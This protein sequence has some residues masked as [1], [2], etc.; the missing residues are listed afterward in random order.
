MKVIV[1]GALGNISKPLA[2]ELIEKGHRVTIISSSPERK[3]DIEAMGATAAIGPLEDPGFVA[4]TFKGADALY[5]MVPPN[6]NAQPDPITYYRNI[7][8]N[9][10]AAIP[11]SGIKRVVHLSS[12]GGELEKGT[13]FIL[14][15]HHVENML[16]A[17]PGIALTHL[18][19]CYFYYN[20]SHFV[21]MIKTA[22]F[23][24]SNY[25]GDDKLVMVAPSDIAAAAAEEIERSATGRDVRY[26]ASDD[27]TASEA[28]HILGAAIGKPD[29]QWMTFTDEQTQKGMEQSGIPAHVAA[30]WVELG[31][32]IHSG[33]L[34][35]DYDLHKPAIMGKVKLKDFAKEFAA[36]FNKG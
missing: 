21:D 1:T 30:L 9:Y 16:A 26:I 27:L 18:R 20:L 17:L 36:A 14:G 4:A 5:A 23:I 7:G 11:P 32:S 34:R 29:L 12:Y 15:A 35:K 13:G 6:H 2:K 3:K 24:G 19:P 10:A 25:G 8:S 33:V 28:A 22:G 31:A